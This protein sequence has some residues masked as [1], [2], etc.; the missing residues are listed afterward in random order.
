MSRF[1]LFCVLFLLP[2]PLFAWETAFDLQL[3]LIDRHDQDL[4]D[5]GSSLSLNRSRLS[6]K[7]SLGDF[8]V[9]YQEE[10]LLYALEHVDSTRLVDLAV[11]RHTAKLKYEAGG[12]KASLALP[13]LDFER[14]VALYEPLAED[15]RSSFLTPYLDL[16]YKLADW[17]G[18]WSLEF[19]HAEEIDPQVLNYHRYGLFRY[20]TDL[21]GPSWQ[22]AESW[23]FGLLFGQNVRDYPQGFDLDKKETYL[24]AK[25]LTPPKLGWAEF[26]HLDIE[27]KRQNTLGENFHRLKGEGLF[28]LKAGSLTHFLNYA[29]VLSEGITVYQQGEWDHSLIELD[30]K[31]KD[32]A[33]W[34]TYSGFTRLGESSWFFAWSA[35]LKD[36]LYRQ[37][38]LDRMAELKLSY[39]F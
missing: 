14:R 25:W 7:E 11:T 24:K 22:M 19:H 4:S 27:L 36:S 3:R 1:L 21:I 10:R 26:A 8:T 15:D 38:F 31:K 20:K 30:L 6:L 37:S 33:Q 2:G 18:P 12:W 39:N 13:S 29:L 34:L 5:Y 35:H 32:L 17:H 23:R 28:K 9:E 16:E